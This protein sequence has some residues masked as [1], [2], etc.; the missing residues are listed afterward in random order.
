MNW[1]RGFKRVAALYVLVAGIV[2]VG[3][4]AWNA[5][6]VD[7]PT[8]YRYTGDQMRRAWITQRLEEKTASLRGKCDVMTPEQAAQREAS[9]RAYDRLGIERDA[10]AKAMK[11]LPPCPADAFKLDPIPYSETIAHTYVVSA[12]EVRECWADPWN[13]HLTKWVAIWAVLIPVVIGLLAAL[14]FGLFRLGRWLYRG[15]KGD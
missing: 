10:F 4:I 6:N 8:E 7:C 13:W 1:R 11:P 9:E 12:S 14:G 15:F 5:L 3:S 2:L